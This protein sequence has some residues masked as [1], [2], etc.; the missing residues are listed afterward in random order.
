ME[1]KLNAEDIFDYV[2]ELG[3]CVA[4][5]HVHGN[6]MTMY[7]YPANQELEIYKNSE[8]MATF[9]YPGQVEQAVYYYNEGG[10]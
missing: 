5:G 9:E 10:Y 6:L 3:H 4:S 2:N 1:I 8:H 7:Y